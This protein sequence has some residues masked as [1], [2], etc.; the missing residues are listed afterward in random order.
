MSSLMD[1]RELAATLRARRGKRGLRQVADEIGGV[2]A[3]TLSRVEQGKLPDIDTFFRICRW[4]D[5]A[6]ER[7]MTAASTHSESS[8]TASD[9]STPQLVAAHLR[10]DRALDPKTAE[11]LITMIQ[12]AYSAIERGELSEDED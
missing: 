3:S 10:A 12:L 7:F 8:A 11:A 9:Q 5:V 4:L 6:P 2:S 1:I